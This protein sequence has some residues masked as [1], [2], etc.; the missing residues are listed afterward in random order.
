MY[1]DPVDD[2]ASTAQ[3]ARKPRLHALLG[4]WYRASKRDLPWRR[5]RDPYAIWLSEVM[6]QQTRVETVV[7]Y[8]TRFL[9]R[10][11]TVRALADAPLD[12]VLSMWSGLGY[13]R[14]ARMLHAGAKHVAARGAFPSDVAALREVP[15]VGPYTAGAI[16]SIAF[17]RRAA[18]VDGN[19]AR[20]LARI[21]A[22][23]D[24]VRGGA[25]LARVWEIAESLVPEEA[26]GDWN[27]ALMELGATVCTPR[28]PRCLVCPVRDACDAR[29]AG[30]ERALPV[31]R[32]KTK[33]RPA[34]RAAI[35]LMSSAGILLARRRPDGLFGGLWEPPSID[36]DADVADDAVAT[37]AR[38]RFAKLLGARIAELE[39]CG[40]IVHVLSHRRLQVFVSRAH[41]PA[42]ARAKV[43]KSGEYDAVER[44]L[45]GALRERGIATLARK[46]LA[47][48]GALSPEAC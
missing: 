45:P 31:L 34:R 40:A 32:A 13:Y 41:L 43:A 9:D 12:D 6:L 38:P 11:A 30:K 29:R 28:E 23:E 2:P 19:V 4:D 16:A 44:V 21:F 36:V 5:T 42:R 46:I 26:A 3:T 37:W 39:P 24:D 18:L 7:P 20:V 33:P 25:G 10:Y 14:R 35:V 47:A 27:Q 48:A 22:I 1:V 17:G 8:Y 15:G